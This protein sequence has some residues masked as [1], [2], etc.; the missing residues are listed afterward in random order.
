M[1]IGDSIP[2]TSL[3]QCYQNQ[4]PARYSDSSLKVETGQLQNR[5]N[6][7][8]VVDISPDGWAAYGKVNAQ[9]GS[10][11]PTEVNS[12]E[13][14][15][16]ASRKYVDGSSDSTVSFQSPT[17]VA[18][19][20]A[21]AAVSSHESEHVANEQARADEEGREVVSQSVRLIT[22]ICP[23]CKRVYVAGGV[24]QTVTVKKDQGQQ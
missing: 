16:C 9:S 1:H 11:K 4:A 17:H 23:E 13:C 20:Q 12:T 24:T 8:V 15:T 18:P 19:G 7:G 14:K 6:P 22:A 2:Q 3:S 21:A 10:A 5:S